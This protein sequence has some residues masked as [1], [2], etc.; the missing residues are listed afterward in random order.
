MKTK[1]GRAV[2]SGIVSCFLAGS[3][4]AQSEAV[5]IRS[6]IEQ[7]Q[8]RATDTVRTSW[9]RGGDRVRSIRGPLSGPSSLD[10]DAAA[11]SFLNENAAIFGMLSGSGS[12]GCYQESWRAPCPV[13]TTLR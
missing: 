11:Q 3:V 4:F 2:S 8:S 12:H 1:F 13:G 9:Y 7:L 6:G 10:P 5:A